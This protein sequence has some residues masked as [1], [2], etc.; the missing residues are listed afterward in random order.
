MTEVQCPKCGGF[1]GNDWSQCNGSCPMP[2]S[3]HYVEREEV[4]L[5]QWL[6]HSAKRVKDHIEE[7]HLYSAHGNQQQVAGAR[8]D[9]LLYMLD[10][11]ATLLS[12]LA[13][14]PNIRNMPNG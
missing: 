7:I 1:H 3:P 11:Y 2:G 4:R 8:R 13:Q 5:D 6:A 9:A 12:A 14:H 10:N